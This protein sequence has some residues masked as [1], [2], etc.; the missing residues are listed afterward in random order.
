MKTKL[1]LYTLLTITMIV[2]L[3]FAMIYSCESILDTTKQPAYGVFAVFITLISTL[4]SIDKLHDVIIEFK[5][6]TGLNF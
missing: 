3:M 5:Q 2:L 4:V 1:A 6:Q